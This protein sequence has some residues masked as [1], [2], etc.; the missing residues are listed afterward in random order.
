MCD[1]RSRLPG[2]PETLYAKLDDMPGTQVKPADIGIEADQVP[3]ETHR[4]NDLPS[5]AQSQSPTVHAPLTE[6][7]LELVPVPCG[8]DADV[9]DDA[10]TAADADGEEAA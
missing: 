2:V 10:G 4:V 9:A 8:T 6:P 1:R 5:A 3:P 7:E